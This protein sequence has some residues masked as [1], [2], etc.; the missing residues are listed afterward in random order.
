MDGTRHAGR[1]GENFSDGAA[2]TRIGDRNFLYGWETIRAATQ[3]NPEATTWRV[4]GVR[5]RRHRYNLVTPDHAVTLEVHRLDSTEG[6]DTWSLMV[7]HEYWW[8]E[9]HKRVRNN[10]WAS[11][12]AGSRLRLADWMAHQGRTIDKSR[13]VQG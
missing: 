2:M 9:R 12:L 6:S 10:L 3:P 7:V 8:D 11:H 1:S 5:W 4:G 13:Q